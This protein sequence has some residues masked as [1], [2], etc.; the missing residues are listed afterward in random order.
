MFERSTI[1]RILKKYGWIANSI[2]QAWLI[3]IIIT[4]FVKAVSNQ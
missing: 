2:I 1:L 3:V 4:F